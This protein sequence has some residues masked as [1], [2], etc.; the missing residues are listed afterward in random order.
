MVEGLLLFN[1]EVL[2]IHSLA[3]G[4]ILACSEL[5]AFPRLHHPL[6]AVTHPPLTSPSSSLQPAH[7]LVQVDRCA[8]K[9]LW[10]ALKSSEII[11]L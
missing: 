1:W 6:P 11:C 9:V 2:S 10:K 5:S 3:L 4:Y 7:C 8:F